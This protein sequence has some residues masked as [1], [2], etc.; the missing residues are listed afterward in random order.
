MLI[1]KDVLHSIVRA[2]AI[3][4]HE[5]VLEIGPGTGNLT[6]LMLEKAGA[7]T[8]VELDDDLFALLQARIERL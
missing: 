8:A 6:V 7:V 1:R 2:A 5:H 3:Q 4:P